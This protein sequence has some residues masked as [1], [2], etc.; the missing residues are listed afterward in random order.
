MAVVLFD[1]EEARGERSFERD[2]RFYERRL[3]IRAWKDRLPEAGA[4]FRGGFAK[5]SLTDRSSANL[6]RF[7]AETRRAEYVH[8][9]NVVAGPVFLLFLPLW[10]GLVMVA[11]AL[12]VHMPF[13][14]IQRYNRIR[15]QRTL[16]ARARREARRAGEAPQTA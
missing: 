5:D 7:V 1:A 4:Y 12:T 16:D 15:L 11:F 8:W 3:R 2:G 6:Q 13:V 14:A 10:G 9:T